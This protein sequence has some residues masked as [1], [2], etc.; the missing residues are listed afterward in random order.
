MGTFTY[1]L[2]VSIVLLFVIH[3]VVLSYY[4][5]ANYG[6][7]IYPG[8]HY[9]VGPR[10][11]TV[12]DLPLE[13]PA[14]RLTEGYMKAQRKLL[15]S[16]IGL[17][18][19]AGIEC[20]LSGG[21][22]LGF[23]R[24]GTFIP[25]DDDIDMHVCWEHKDFMFSQ[26]FCDDAK[27][28]GLEVIFLIGCSAKRTTKESGAV[29][30]RNAGTSTPVCDV[31]FVKQREGEARV[32]KVDSWQNKTV[33]FNSAEDWEKNDIFP[34]TNTY[35]DGLMLP[36]PHK[37]VRVLERQYG[38]RVMSRMFARSTLFSHQYVYSFLFLL[39]RRGRAP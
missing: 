33:V 1:L 16:V 6:A 11:Y 34:I 30:L 17:L 22:L 7:R 37:P 12:P 39:W 3:V 35:V 14:R 28:H 8:D 38:N 32:G 9:T 13:G 25:W 21:T 15:S 26:R 4:S 29:R 27:A 20:W 19:D 24:H 23:T 2:C 5:T 18:N 10:G 36:V 31:F